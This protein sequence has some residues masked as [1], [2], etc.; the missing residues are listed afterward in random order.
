MV[1]TVLATRWLCLMKAR[2]RSERK[3]M[4]R[5]QPCGIEHLRWWHSPSPV[6]YAPTTCMHSECAA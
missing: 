5:G 1:L 4:L 3:H 6:L 2:V